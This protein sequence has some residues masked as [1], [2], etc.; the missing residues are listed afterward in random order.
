[1]L[2]KLKGT[3][4]NYLQMN[5]KQGIKSCETPK[6]AMGNHEGRNYLNIKHSILK[7]Y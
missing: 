3:G 1:M 4:Y 5:M 6:S 7:L 2:L